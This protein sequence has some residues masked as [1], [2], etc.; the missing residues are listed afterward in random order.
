MIKITSSFSIN[1]FIITILFF[2]LLILGRLLLIPFHRCL[3]ISLW[4]SRC[5]LTFRM[6][7]SFF[8]TSRAED[9]WS[10]IFDILWRCERAGCLYVGVWVSCLGP[11]IV[12]KPKVFRVLEQEI[13]KSLHKHTHTQTHTQKKKH[14]SR[15]IVASGRALGEFSDKRAGSSHLN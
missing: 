14:L 13:K 12:K 11:P 1:M 2:A 6:S 5:V 8:K 15:H 7:C 10:L 9:D 4:L 3:L